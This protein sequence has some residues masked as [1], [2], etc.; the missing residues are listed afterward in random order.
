MVFDEKFHTIAWEEFLEK[1]I[2]RKVTQEEMDKYEIVLTSTVL[3]TK[4]NQT[5][6]EKNSSLEEGKEKVIQ[7]G[8]TGKT[9][10][11]YKIVKNPDGSIKSKT[12]LSKDT[13]KPMNR[14]VEVG[15]KKVA[16]T[17][18]IVTQPVTPSVLT[19]PTTVIT[20]SVSL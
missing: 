2:G 20:N 1:R 17:T 6:Y 19:T 10:I 11:A 14:I 8:Y 9:S 15:T 13:Y 5:V 4:A 7:S 3:S 18:P 16:P 12:V